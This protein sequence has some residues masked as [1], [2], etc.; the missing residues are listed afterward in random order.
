MNLTPCDRLRTR[1]AVDDTFAVIHRA[2]ETIR[3]LYGEVGSIQDDDKRR[4]FAQHITRSESHSRIMDR[5][6][7][8]K[9]EP[10]I[11]VGPQQLDSH[12]WVLNVCVRGRDR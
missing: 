10:G 12:P 8:A 3:S 5:I 7:L 2:K 1:W 11:P 4:S 6:E 9:S